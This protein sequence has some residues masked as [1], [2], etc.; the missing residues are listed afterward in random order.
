[1]TVGVRPLTGKDLA[2]ALPAVARLRIAVFRDWPYLYDGS[3]AYEEKYLAKLAAAQGAIVVAA[4]EGADIVG[5]ATGAPLAQVEAELARPFRERGLDA[6]RI[7][8]CG[9]SVL[10]PAYRGRGI[11]HA[12]FDRREAHARALG[13]FTHIAFC[14]V[15]RPEGI[16]CARRSM[17]RST[18]SGTSAAMPKPRPRRPLRL[19]GCRPAGGDGEAHAVLDEGALVAGLRIAAAQYPIEPL[20]T[21]GAC[22]DKLARWVAEAAGEGAGLLVFPEY[23]AMEYAAPAGA[24]V[25]GDLAASLAAVSDALGPMDEAHAELA[26][27]HGVHILAGSGPSARAEGRIVNA[28]RLVSPA[29]KAGV[30]EK[31]TMTPFERDW[32]ISGGTPL[33]VF[34]TALGRIGVAICY[35]AEFPLIVRA[36]CEAGAEIVLVPSCT[37]F[38]S[39]Y[40]RVHGA[41]AR[42][43]ERLRHRGVAGRR[44]CPGRRPS[45]AT[46]GPPGCS[47]QPTHGFS[48]TGVLA[49]GTLNRPQWVYARADLERLRKV[50]AAGEMRNATDWLAQP[51][52]VGSPTREIVDLTQTAEP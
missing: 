28:A 12:F 2:G 23:A 3:L 44:R 40:H 42:A 35:D 11:G 9:E 50:K 31:L 27:R 21:L 20:R 13:G 7:F 4:C 51:G 37:E 33:R 19:E 29:G 1:M 45:I 8:Y 17:C 38:V 43:G 30:Q 49:E 41:G 36:Q 22:R 14:A 46:P 24:P 25:A 34:Q 16:R 47:S 5:C 52:A 39:G 18:R 15:V 32:G 6:A 26:R 10:L 48:E